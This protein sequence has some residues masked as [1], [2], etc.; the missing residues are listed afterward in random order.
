MCCCKCRF[1]DSVQ[2][3]EEYIGYYM[4]TYYNYVGTVYL[5]TVI[6]IVKLVAS[7][8]KKRG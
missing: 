7:Y 4:H 6:D 2:Y 1:F 8:T 5:V 3:D